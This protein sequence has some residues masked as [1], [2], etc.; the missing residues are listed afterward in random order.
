MTG[1]SILPEVVDHDDDRIDRGHIARMM[2]I[3]DT[4]KAVIQFSPDLHGITPK[5]DKLEDDKPISSTDEVLM[6][7]VIFSLIE[8][9]VENYKEDA[10]GQIIRTRPNVIMGAIKKSG[11][12][13]EQYY[14]MIENPEFIAL[15]QRIE[16]GVFI[17]SQRPAML[18]AASKS[19][20][21]GDT[22]ALKLLLEQKSDEA[23]G[24]QRMINEL[25]DMGDDAIRRHA[26]EQMNILDKQLTIMGKAKIDDDSISAARSE[27][28]KIDTKTDCA[29]GEDDIALF[30][31][32]LK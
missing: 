28:A 14:Q 8:A 7:R 9:Y 22:Q 32:L 13:L 17:E 6:R 20:M 1:E 3:F 2:D 27:V 21:N 18:Q 30:Q 25:I 26:V 10:S 29:T 5:I 16:N 23:E 4:K 24:L 11:A 15:K 19:A 31:H 12:T